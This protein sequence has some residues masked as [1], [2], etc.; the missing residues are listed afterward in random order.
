M[1]RNKFVR[2]EPPQLGYGSGGIDLHYQSLSTTVLQTVGFNYFHYPAIK[3]FLV[4]A[5][6]HGVI[7]GYS[8]KPVYLVVNFGWR[9]D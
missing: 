3:G 6:L 8:L 1:K 9:C 7:H 2:Q 4:R 5:P